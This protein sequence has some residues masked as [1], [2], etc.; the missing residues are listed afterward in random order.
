MAFFF[1]GLIMEPLEM[2]FQA[3]RLLKPWLY[4]AFQIYKAMLATVFLIFAI[5]AVRIDMSRNVLDSETT[6]NTLPIWFS[7]SSVARTCQA[8]GN[9]SASL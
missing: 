5:Y 1:I 4:L 7:T 9:T 3:Y 8:C 6:A 2:V